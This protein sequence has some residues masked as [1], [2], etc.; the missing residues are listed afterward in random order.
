MPFGRG[1]RHR[2]NQSGEG[3]G[4]RKDGVRGPE[5]SR[6]MTGKSASLLLVVLTILLL[7]FGVAPADIPWLQQLVVASM[8]KLGSLLVVRSPRRRPARR[9]R[10]RSRRRGRGRAYSKPRAARRRP[11]RRSWWSAWRRLWRRLWPPTP[12]R[13]RP[14]QKK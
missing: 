10:R 11:A 2:V 8:L 9:A 14:T 7:H 1:G 12:R 5:E 13:R 4:G 3:S 6:F